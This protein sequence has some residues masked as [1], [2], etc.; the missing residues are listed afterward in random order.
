MKKDI[1]PEWKETTVTCNSCG[2]TFKSH[3]TVDEITVEIC[4]HCHPFYTGK[5]KLVDTAGRVDKF[6]A[7]QAAAVSKKEASAK[8]PVK[9]GKT[10]VAAKDSAEQ[11]K[12]I[13]QELEKDT[14]SVAN[15][16]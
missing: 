4:S 15:K 9:T 7:R 6:L 14:V 8:K 12:E 2:T 13:K 5:Q 3:S 1:H 16:Q 11:L 10:K